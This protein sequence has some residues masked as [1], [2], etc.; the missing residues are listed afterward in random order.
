M[1]SFWASRLGLVEDGEQKYYYSIFFQG[2]QV[3]FQGDVCVPLMLKEGS[4]SLHT[5]QAGRQKAS[6]RVLTS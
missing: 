1:A 4:S 3:H 2:V 5:G 6:Y